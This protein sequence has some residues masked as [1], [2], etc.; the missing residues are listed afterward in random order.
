MCKFLSVL[1]FTPLL[2]HA[3][4]PVKPIVSADYMSLINDDSLP[5]KKN[6]TRDSSKIHLRIKEPYSDQ[7]RVRAIRERKG[8]LTILPVKTKWFSIGGNYTFSAAARSVNTMPSLQN[9][10]VQ[11]ESSN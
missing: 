9:E 4:Q 8:T 1:L 5:G 7:Y 11:G 2:M 6:T 3:Q 10:Y